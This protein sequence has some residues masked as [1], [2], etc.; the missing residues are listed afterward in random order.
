MIYLYIAIAFLLGAL[1]GFGATAAGVA[2]LIHDGQLQKTAKW[3][4]EDIKKKRE[5]RARKDRRT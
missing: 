3:Y 4:Q 1:V 2:A 5:K